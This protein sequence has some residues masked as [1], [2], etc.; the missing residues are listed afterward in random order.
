MSWQTEAVQRLRLLSG[1]TIADYSDDQLTLLFFYSAE[2]TNLENR[3]AY[4]YT[5]LPSSTGILP[6]PAD[7]DP[8][9]SSFMVLTTMK[10]ICRLRNAELKLAA[11][12]S[13]R[14]KDGISE[15]ETKDYYKNLQAAAQLACKS[16]TDAQWQQEVFYAAN[17]GGMQAILGPFTNENFY[18]G[19]L[20]YHDFL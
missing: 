10:S 18:Y 7:S 13:F 16:Y 6:D 20:A 3:F 8:R 14:V 15:I 9:D 17:A 1:D 19:S 12:S 4:T 11:G 5:F 2:E